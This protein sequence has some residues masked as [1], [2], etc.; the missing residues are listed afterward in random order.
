MSATYETIAIVGV[1]L[2]GG[3]IGLAARKRGVA[4]RVVGIGRHLE[5]LKIAEQLGAITEATTD[6]EA[7]ARQAQLVVVCTPAGAVAEIVRSL[8][9]S[10]A[11]G[12]LI[13]DAASTKAGIVTNLQAEVQQGLRFVGSHPL[14][15]SHLT[16]VQAADADLFESRQV[17]VTPSESTANAD[18]DQIS[19]FWS[20]LGGSVTQMT[21][22]EHDRA[23]A[24]T[25]HVPHIVASALAAATPAEF[26]QFVASGWRD[27]TRVAAGSVELWRDILNENRVNI[28]NSLDN[29]AQGLDEFRDAIE[30]ND[31]QSI[32]R[33]LE[34]G[35]QQRD[36]VGN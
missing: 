27:T 5:N 36:L 21:A 2:I 1:G 17:I 20:S 11:S 14:A 18:C 4:V 16:G 8:G 34:H 31:Q 19:Q 23:L 28:L 9:A 12:S 32:T 33:M 3:S 35:K 29:L 22:T 15:G 10:M 25:S 7:G 6:L 24:M 26:L 30:T 13:T